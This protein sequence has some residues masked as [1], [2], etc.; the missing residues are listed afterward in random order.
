MRRTSTESSLIKSVG[1]NSLTSTLELKYEDGTIFQYFDVPEN[2][3]RRLLKPG[4]GSWWTDRWSD[5]SYNKI[6]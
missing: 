3:Y 4:A 2:V 6:Q 5:H 1:Y